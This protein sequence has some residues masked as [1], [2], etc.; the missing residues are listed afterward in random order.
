MESS[1]SQGMRGAT[2]FLFD[3][4]FFY[5]KKSNAPALE[6]RVSPSPCPPFQNLLSQAGMPAP[7]ANVCL[8]GETLG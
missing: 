1:T 8:V 3:D 5:G 4:R 7:Y 6:G 2:S